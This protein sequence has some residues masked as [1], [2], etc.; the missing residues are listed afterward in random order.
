M[1]FFQNSCFFRANLLPS[2]YL[3]S[4]IGQLLFGA[5]VFL[6]KEL[7]RIRISTEELLFRS[8]YF[9]T[10]S[11]FSEELHFGKKLIFQKRN[12]PDFRRATVLDSATFSKELTFY[13]GYLF[14]GATF[15]QHT[16]SEELLFHNY[17]SFP[18]LHFLSIS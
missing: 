13:R 15:L 11:T 7:F 17:A 18:Q 2:S 6:A 16:F 10:T 1:L 9:Y 5:A 14:R 4:S 3:G 8:R 12:I